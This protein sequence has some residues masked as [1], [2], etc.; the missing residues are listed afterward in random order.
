MEAEAANKRQKNGQRRRTVLR[1]EK[2]HRRETDKRIG[3]PVK[4]GEARK[5]AERTS[6][7]RRASMAAWPLA[8][9][10]SA[11]SLAAASEESSSRL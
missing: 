8:L 10:W 6:W 5:A 11:A 7:L 3:R 4:I 9:S 1:N 2:G